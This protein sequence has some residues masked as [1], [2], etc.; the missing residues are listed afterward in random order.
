MKGVKI[1]I[2]GQINRIDISMC[3]YAQQAHLRKRG[4]QGATQSR[5]EDTGHI[6]AVAAEQDRFLDS[7]QQVGTNARA[8]E[9]QRKDRSRVNF[10]PIPHNFC[11]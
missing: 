1:S 5:M 11:Q 6:Y 7:R 8:E 9:A 10:P 3:I 2:A 4:K